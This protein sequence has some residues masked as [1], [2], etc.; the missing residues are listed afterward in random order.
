M[1]LD[2]QGDLFAKYIAAE[3]KGQ[4]VARGSTALAVARATGHG[5]STV[6][7]WLNGKREIPVSFTYKACEVI[8][9]DPRQLVQLAEERLAKALR[10]SGS[11]RGSSDQGEAPRAPVSLA[12]RRA[13][14]GGSSENGVQIP[15]DVEQAWADKVAAHDDTEEP[16]DH[17]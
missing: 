4:I 13:N 5:A 14:V 1:D 10:D 8:G 17:D 6:N 15:E 7:A 2:E 16:I 11:E 12:E 3:L 9:I